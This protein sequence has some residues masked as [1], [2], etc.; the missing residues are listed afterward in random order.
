MLCR[1]VAAAAIRLLGA[2]SVAGQP[3]GLTLHNDGLAW[4]ALRLTAVHAA[5]AT[6]GAAS[7]VMWARADE[8][9]AEDSAF[10]DFRHRYSRFPASAAWTGD[11]LGAFATTGHAL[12]LSAVPAKELR[13]LR[14]GMSRASEGPAWAWTWRGRNLRAA[15][16]LRMG[17]DS[18]AHPQRFCIKARC[19]ALCRPLC[20]LERRC[21]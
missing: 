14:S 19:S 6:R 8:G 5:S 20:R 3:T 17:L 2:W 15:L 4:R 7:L 9:P 18:E 10:A 1:R 21:T 16:A 11:R 12:P 13:L